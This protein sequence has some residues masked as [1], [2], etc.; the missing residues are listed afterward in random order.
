VVDSRLPYL[1][2]VGFYQRAVTHPGAFIQQDDVDAVSPART[3]DLL[4]R[5][6]GVRVTTETSG[7]HIRRRVLFNRL[8][9][10]EGELCYPAVFVDDELV[11]I[12]GSRTESQWPVV[13]GVEPPQGEDVPS[14]DEL[15]PP[16]EILA[17][18]MYENA[19]RL[20]G[21]FIGLGTHCGVIVFWTT[22]AR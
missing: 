6:P 11:R 16:H 12:G 8:A 1:E 5:V 9:L 22:R 13:Q 18:E 10:L 21:R 4:G 2:Q 3:S 14:L 17:V 7:G 20:P 15:V 19:A